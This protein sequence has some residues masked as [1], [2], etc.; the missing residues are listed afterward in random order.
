MK[1]GA[2]SYVRPSYTWL[3][4]W[5]KEATPNM[6]FNVTY[7]LDLHGANFIIIIE[8][9]FCQVKLSMFYNIQ[10]TSITFVSRI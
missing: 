3:R 7:Y 10:P 9:K 4:D 6:V 8:I 5:F 2:S 1:V